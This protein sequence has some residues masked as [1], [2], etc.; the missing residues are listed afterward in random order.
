MRKGLTYGALIF[1]S[2]MF[3]MPF[4]WTFITAVKSVS[5]LYQYPPVF[6]PTDVQW[7]KLHHGVV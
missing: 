1:L 3:I 4:Y 2:A 6:W 7:G 5:E